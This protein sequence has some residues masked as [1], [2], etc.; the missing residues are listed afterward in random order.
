MMA[1]VMKNTDHDLSKMLGLFLRDHTTSAKELAR[2]IDC[3]PRT[4]E[5]FRA[6]R[7]WPSARHWQLIARQFGRDVMD[8]VFSPDIDGPLARLT[9][10][11]RVLKERLH[12]IQTRLRSGSRPVD[13]PDE[14]RAPPVDRDP[15][16]LDLF[17]DAR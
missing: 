8:A 16:S 12:E 13:G 4:A 7:Y 2:L 5:G 11:E 3:D 10:E 9:A 15:L 6:G 17:E 1:T 14:R